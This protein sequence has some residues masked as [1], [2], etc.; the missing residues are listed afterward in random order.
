MA[1]YEC[2]SVDQINRKER[3]AYHEL[4]RE[5]YAPLVGY[6]GKY[7]LNEEVSEDL[8]QDVF[9]GLWEGDTLFAN[10]TALRVYLYQAVKNRCLNYLKHWKIERRYAGQKQAGDRETFSS[11]DFDQLEEEI[12]RQLLKAV[13]ELPPRCRQVFE[14]HLE[15]RRNDEIA[16]LLGVSV[17]T[18]KAQKQKAVHQLRDRLSG[19]VLFFAASRFF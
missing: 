15:G 5:F 12:Y 10:E 17:L 14:L 4:F 7:V 8:V 19:I 13:K 6:A 2:L 9:V 11:V 16:S 3:A 18:V 1:G